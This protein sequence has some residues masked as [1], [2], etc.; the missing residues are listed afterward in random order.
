MSAERCTPAR[1]PFAGKHNDKNFHCNINVLRELYDNH[2]N[3]D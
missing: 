1:R 2:R 3:V